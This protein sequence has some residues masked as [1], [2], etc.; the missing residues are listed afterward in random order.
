MYYAFSCIFVI[1]L[2]FCTNVGYS[3]GTINLFVFD[4][5]GSVIHFCR[6]RNVVLHCFVFFVCLFRG[7]PIC[8]KKVRKQYIW[9]SEKSRIEYFASCSEEKRIKR[10]KWIIQFRI[11]CLVLKNFNL[12]NW[13]SK[14][15]TVCSQ[16]I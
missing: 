12:F 4:Y 9:A 10:T 16:V 14:V 3:I 11:K 15:C 6:S 7:K 5:L 2:L 8:T 13:I 1:P